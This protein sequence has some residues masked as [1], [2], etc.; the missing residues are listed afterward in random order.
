MI[1]QAKTELDTIRIAAEEA[2]TQCEVSI[3]TQ[4]AALEILNADLAISEKVENM[5][6]CDEDSTSMLQ[7]GSGYAQRFH[8]AGKAAAPLQNFKSKAALVARERAARM[9]LKKP[10]KQFAFK[11][12]HKPKHHLNL[13]SQKKNLGKRALKQEPEVSPEA[14]GVNKTTEAS[15]D[16]LESIEN[17]TVAAMP[18]PVSN[19]HIG[20]CSVSGS[21]MCPMLRDALSQ[22]TAE[23]RWARDLAAQGL[24]ET[25]AECQRLATE[26]KQQSDDWA[27][28]LQENN[29]KFS[30]ATG[31]LNT[32]E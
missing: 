17:L 27:M 4:K 25:E 18:P 1:T 7:C 28:I 21:P 15:D 20:K 30:T 24:A 16:V 32:A 13:A 22:L 9:A 26:Y 3:N 31:N 11:K 6:Q 23:I 19:D 29:V 5:T 8:F 12:H 10:L 2:A 14:E